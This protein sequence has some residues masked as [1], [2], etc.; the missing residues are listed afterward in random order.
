MNG[1]K[2]LKYLQSKRIDD[3]S[4]YGGNADILMDPT[5]EKVGFVTDL[6]SNKAYGFFE[7][8]IDR[9]EPIEQVYPIIDV[10]AT[11]QAALRRTRPEPNKGLGFGHS[12]SSGTWGNTTIT[13]T[14]QGDQTMDEF[15]GQETEYWEHRLIQGVLGTQ[16][17]T[18]QRFK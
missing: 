14:Q 13:T 5:D 1:K 15:W 18:S 11:E 2:Y 9:K 16:A 12:T 4:T 8:D 10:S 3:K 7:D 6:D 17:Y